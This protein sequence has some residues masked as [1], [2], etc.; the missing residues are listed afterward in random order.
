MWIFLK[1]KKQ[2]QLK[3]KIISYSENFSSAYIKEGKFIFQ[4][5]DEADA[6]T[7]RFTQP[8]CH[9]EVHLQLNS[10]AFSLSGGER[11]ESVH[12]F[13]KDSLSDYQEPVSLGSEETT[14]IK[15]P[16]VS[17]WREHSEATR[18]TEPSPGPG[19]PSQRSIYSMTWPVPTYLSNFISLSLYINEKSKVAVNACH[20][21]ACLQL[22]LGQTCPRKGHPDVWV[23]KGE[24]RGPNFCLVKLGLYIGILKFIR[25][26]NL[27]QPYDIEAESDNRRKKNFYLTKQS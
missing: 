13:N 18:V 12:L 19:H 26:K 27:K 25:L 16:Q 20:W 11:W 17:V 14:L 21:G 2:L 1:N 10:F 6:I 7:P 5:G 24:I 4:N 3:D 9:S 15:E 8:Q 23:L 22:L